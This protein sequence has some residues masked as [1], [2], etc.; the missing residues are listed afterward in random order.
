M[1]QFVQ[2]KGEPTYLQIYELNDSLSN[3]DRMSSST[4][5]TVKFWL[6]KIC[7][8]QIAHFFLFAKFHLPEIVKEFLKK[9]LIF[10]SILH[11]FFFLKWI[12]KNYFHFVNP[13]FSIISH[14]PPQRYNFINFT[15]RN[16]P[17]SFFITWIPPVK[18]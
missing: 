10:L 3:H 5:H 14:S 7:K 11:L 16:S 8:F 15:K 1:I 12:K 2:F 13:N 18:M 9:N 17:N 4:P 6:K